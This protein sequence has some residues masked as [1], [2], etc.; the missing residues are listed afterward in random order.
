MKVFKSALL[1]G[2]RL[3][4]TTASKEVDVAERKKKSGTSDSIWSESLAEMAGRQ[5]EWI[6]DRK[7][8]RAGVSAV[9][10]TPVENGIGVILNR[11][12]SGH[13]TAAGQLSTPAGIWEGN[14]DLKTAAMRELGEEVILKDGNCLGYWSFD[15]GLLSPEWVGE[16][17]QAHKLKTINFY[18]PIS[19]YEMEGLVEIVLDGHPQGKALLAY[20]PITGGIEILFVFETTVCVNGMIVDGERFKEEWLHREVGVFTLD[21][22]IKEEKKTTKVEAVEALLHN[23]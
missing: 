2:N 17:S 20:E 5:G 14:E 13:P 10:L 4:L 15:F 8:L 9:V 11:F 23:L 18:V 16:Y 12:D 21:Q 19:P 1:I 3:N 7:R 22:L 6:Q